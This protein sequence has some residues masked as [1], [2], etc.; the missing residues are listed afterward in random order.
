MIR[1]SAKLD[2]EL[3]MRKCQEIFDT[4][5]DMKRFVADERTRTCHF[6]GDHDSFT[7]DDVKLESYCDYYYG[8]CLHNCSKVFVRNRIVGYCGE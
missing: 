6:I 5:D 7:K 2:S 3:W 8:L 4:I 1:Y